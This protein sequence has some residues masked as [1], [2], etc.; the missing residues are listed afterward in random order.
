MRKIAREICERQ[1]AK[2]L[3]IFPLQNAEIAIF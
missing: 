2:D 1:I 3:K